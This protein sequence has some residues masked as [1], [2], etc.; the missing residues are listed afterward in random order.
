MTFVQIGRVI[1][2][3]RKGLRLSQSRLSELA[4]CSKPSVI[5]AEHGKPTLRLDILLAI[6]TVL[7]L[8]LDITPS[9]RSP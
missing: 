6:L 2:E 8:E 5:A 7:G 4:S 9:D 1:R 3:R